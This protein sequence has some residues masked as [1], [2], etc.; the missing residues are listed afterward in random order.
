MSHRWACLTF[1]L[2]CW[3]CLNKVTL[4]APTKFEP[5]VIVILSAIRWGKRDLWWL[6]TWLCYRTIGL[7]NMSSAPSIVVDTICLTGRW[8]DSKIPIFLHRFIGKHTLY[9]LRSAAYT[10]IH[11]HALPVA[12]TSPNIKYH[13]F[14][15]FFWFCASFCSWFRQQW[16]QEFQKCTSFFFCCWIDVFFPALITLNF[17]SA[18]IILEDSPLIKFCAPC[19]RQV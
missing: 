19:S 9:Q 15:F 4:V 3:Q 7:M 5:P 14:I 10:M 6:F 8:I 12:Q 16:H 13:S 18:A 17:L 11:H 1:S 2:K